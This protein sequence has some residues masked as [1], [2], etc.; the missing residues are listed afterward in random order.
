MYGGQIW[1]CHKKVKGQLT[2]IIWTKL[3]D[4][5]SPT[6]YTKIQPKNFLYSGDFYVF[7]PYMGIA[8]IL[9]KGAEP[10]EQIINTLLT[11]G[12]IWNLVKI[13][14]AGDVQNMFSQHFPI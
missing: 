13:A 14:R 1:P 3:V 11:E 5:E 9:F 2:P 10:F 7:L 4:L 8:V 6:L 12:P